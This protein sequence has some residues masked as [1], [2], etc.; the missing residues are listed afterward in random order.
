[1]RAGKRGPTAT[2]TGL[3]T[4]GWRGAVRGSERSTRTARTGSCEE[5]TGLHC[6]AVVDTNR[7]VSSLLLT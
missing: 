1:M 3:A 2:A 4:F 6:L 7:L 5:Q